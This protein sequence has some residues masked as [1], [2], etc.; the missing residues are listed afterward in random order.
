MKLKPDIAV[1]DTKCANFHSVC[2]A[3]DKVGAVPRIVSCP[4]DFEPA[5]GAVL[6]GVGSSDTAM[7]ALDRN[8]LREPLLK[9]TRSG[10]PLLSVCVGMQI[11]FQTSK[12]GEMPTLGLLCGSV[13]KI[14]TAS[15]EPPLKIPH[16]GWNDIAVGPAKAHPIFH[17]LNGGE[18]FYFVHSYFCVPSKED[19]VAA[20]ADY[21]GNFCAAVAQ[22]NIA[23]VQFHA[24]KSGDEGLKI[25]RNFV[26]WTLSLKGADKGEGQ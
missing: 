2:K 11:L 6:P 22:D 23:G 20:S 3:L 8:H 13:Q 5:D 21:G 10:R 1:I 16:M 25:Y 9:F 15:S 4:E 14:S 19:I 26:E 17:H 7:N 18:E 24:E 12:E